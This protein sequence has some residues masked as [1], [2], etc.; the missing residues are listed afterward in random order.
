MVKIAL[1]QCRPGMDALKNM[2]A[3]AAVEGC[4]A[5]CFAEGSLTG[6]HG[7]PIPWNGAETAEVSALARKLEIDI[8]CGFLEQEGD[9]EYIAHALFRPDG[10]A[11]RYRKTH[12]G[13]K[14]AARFTPGDT[15]PVFELSCALKAGIMLC[16]ETH[17]PRVAETLALRGAQVLFAPFSVVRKAGEREKVWGKYIPARAYDNRVYVGCCN[18]LDDHFPGGLLAVG[19]DGATLSSYYEPHEKLLVFSADADILA[20]YGA[21]GTPPRLR[22]FTDLRRTGLYD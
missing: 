3:A 16:I 21:Q 17:V 2:A 10:A 8:L 19:P 18:A 12:L 4:S 6:Y 14:E 22:R 13:E 5:V 15:L 7:D 20:S 9:R 11:F 1:A